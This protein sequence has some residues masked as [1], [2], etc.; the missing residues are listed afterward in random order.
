MKGV[1]RL[2][3]L[4]RVVIGLYQL[5]VE[6]EHMNDDAYLFQPKV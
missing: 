2:G 1:D 4:Q 5:L 3:H 6:H